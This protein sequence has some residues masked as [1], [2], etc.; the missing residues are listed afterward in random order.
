LRIKSN[1]KAKAMGYEFKNINYNKE[2]AMAAPII[3]K[4]I[5]ANR[6]SQDPKRTIID[7]LVELDSLGGTLAKG[8]MNSFWLQTRKT[9]GHTQHLLIPSYLALVKSAREFG[10]IKA[11]VVQLV[12]KDEEFYELPTFKYGD[13]PFYHKKRPLTATG[14]DFIGGYWFLE[15]K[16]GGFEWGSVNNEELNKIKNSGSTTAVYSKWGAEMAKKGI[17]KRAVKTHRT[18]PI[19]EKMVANDNSQ[20]EAIEIP[21]VEYEPYVEPVENISKEE[22]LERGYA[23]IVEKYAMSWEGYTTA[24]QFT[25][26]KEKVVKTAPNKRLGELLQEKL[27][28]IFY[29]KFPKIEEKPTVQD[30]DTLEGLLISISDFTTKEDFEIFE[31]KALPT[32]K[33][34]MLAMVTEKFYAIYH[35]RYPK[36]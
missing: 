18:N 23:A 13:I 26:A 33:G 25:G 27:L 21:E 20:F 9:G 4:G 10:G 5:E 30:T 6:S 28:E 11:I 29:K 12:Y 2:Y 14:D 19:F 36:S 32:F 8:A 15:T 16:D 3:M 34:Q 7:A 35:E 22:K 31:Q 24:A 1:T 17:F